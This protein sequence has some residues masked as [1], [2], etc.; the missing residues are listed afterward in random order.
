MAFH[1]IAGEEQVRGAGV[2]D[3]KLGADL[4]TIVDEGR[5][6]RVDRRRFRSLGQSDA[7][8]A[9]ARGPRIG[10]GEIISVR[11]VGGKCDP[12]ADRSEEHTY[13]LKSLMRISYAVF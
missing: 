3:E 12:Q 8:A 9:H 7:D 11:G 5:A 1:V 10:A 2:Q 13:E 6:G 4:E